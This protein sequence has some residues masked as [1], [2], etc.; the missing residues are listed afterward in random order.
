MPET[1]KSLTNC[2]RSTKQKHKK[3]KIKRKLLIPSLCS[4]VRAIPRVCVR[5]SVCV[6]WCAVCGGWVVLVR[7]CWFCLCVRREAV[8]V[9]VCV[10]RVAAFVLASAAEFNVLFCVVV[11]DSWCLCDLS[12]TPPSDYAGAGFYSGRFRLEFV[13]IDL[14]NTP[15]WDENRGSAW[16]VSDWTVTGCFG[17]IG[18]NK[19][20]KKR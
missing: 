1:L 7:L 12:S 10:V 8:C 9:S 5:G 16:T 6:C 20:Y 3:K 2:P 17:F 4:E 14:K 19:I 11:M 18:Q 13:T 15:D